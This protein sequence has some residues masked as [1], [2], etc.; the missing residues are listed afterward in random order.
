MGKIL[1]VNGFRIYIYSNDHPPVHVHVFKGGSEA[2]VHLE[3]ELMIKDNYGFKSQGLA[4]I[5]KTIEQHYEYIKQKWD[6]TYN[7]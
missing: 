3:P 1:E 2:K 5:L 4:K 7:Q 6:E